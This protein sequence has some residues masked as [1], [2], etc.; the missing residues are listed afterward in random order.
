[1]P[2]L[3]RIFAE[4]EAEPGQ[5]TSAILSFALWQSQFG[6]DPTAL[7]RDLRIDGHSYT[8]VGVMPKTFALISPDVLVWTPLTLTPAEKISRYNDVWG[9]IARLKTGSS[10]EQARAE[11]DAI[12]RVNLERF[13]Q[14][15]RVISDAGFYTVVEGLQDS[16]V[17][18]VRPA[19]RLMWGGSCFVLL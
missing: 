8:I 1:A 18:E 11:I 7:G 19:L 17:K 5:G 15:K 14:F 2:S 3:G 13:P 6:G 12:A 16:L 4:T 10:I 9:Y